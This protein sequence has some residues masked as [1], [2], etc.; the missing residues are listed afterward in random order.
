M[1]PSSPIGFDIEL[2]ARRSSSR[3]SPGP[4]RNRR[5]GMRRFIVAKSHIGACWLFFL[6]AALSASIG[7]SDGARAQVITG[8]SATPSSYS[9][10]NQKI[11]F[12]ININSGNFVVEG[13][14]VVSSI[15][16]NYSCSGWAGGQT[17]QNVTCVGAYVTK[18]GDMAN[19]IQE[20]PT[21]TLMALGNIPHQLNYQGGNMVIS[22]AVAAPKAPA[23]VCD[24][25][26]AQTCSSLVQDQIYWTLDNTRDPAS[27]HWT[28]ANLN[29]LCGCTTDPPTTVLCF[30]NAL[31][32]NGGAHL[33]LMQAINMCAK[34]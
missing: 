21:V 17:G 28:S 26:K 12:K 2:T 1:N 31:W 18:P 22:V 11:T 4:A 27:K 5:S 16:V 6:A 34:K 10:A 23:A 33:P 9:R 14:N 24:A 15:G 20:S 19:A 30:Q 8:F 29:A 13:V 32:N 25:G 3:G 7:L